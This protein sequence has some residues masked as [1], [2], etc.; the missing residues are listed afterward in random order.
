MILKKN[1]WN[2]FKTIITIVVLSV[3]QIALA[4]S[5]WDAW[6]DSTAWLPLK[7]NQGIDPMLAN[8]MPVEVA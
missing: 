7:T 3:S 1:Q 2:T 5:H 6:Q 8:K 4:L